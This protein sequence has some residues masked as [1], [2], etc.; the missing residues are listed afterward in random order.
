MTFLDSI[1]YSFSNPD[2]PLREIFKIKEKENADTN[3][4]GFTYIR[5]GFGQLN[6]LSIGHRYVLEIWPPGNKSPLHN[7]GDSSGI[8]SMIHGAVNM[9]F[10]EQVDRNPI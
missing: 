9:K 4:K 5:L 3:K 8:V 6:F 7:H 10:F 2:S 1:V